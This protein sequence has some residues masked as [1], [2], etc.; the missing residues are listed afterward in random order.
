MVA[1]ILADRGDVLLR[2]AVDATV[3]LLSPHR[4]LITR[5][6][7]GAFTCPKIGHRESYGEV[8]MRLGSD[9]RLLMS[10]YL[11]PLGSVQGRPKSM[12]RNRSYRDIPQVVPAAVSRRASFRAIRILAILVT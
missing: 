9:R 5:R 11:R 7:I 4:G 8:R 1:A 2:C 6:S 12:G 10:T 3:R